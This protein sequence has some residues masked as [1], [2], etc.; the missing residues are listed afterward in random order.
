[1]LFGTPRVTCRPGA[2]QGLFPRG[3]DFGSREEEDDP[4]SSW[5]VRPQ[6][7]YVRK[8]VGKAPLLRPGRGPSASPYRALPGGTPFVIGVQILT[9]TLFCDSASDE[10]CISTKSC[11]YGRF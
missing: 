3:Q 2:P 5:I 7:Q 11:L 6:P 8:R 9:N 1:M 4:A 10:G